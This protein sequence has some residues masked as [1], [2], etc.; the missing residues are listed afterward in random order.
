MQWEYR[1]ILFEFQKDGL[2]GDTFIDDEDIE[3]TLNE[4]GLQGW[5]LVNVAL[6]Q[7]GLLAFC[8]RQ[9]ITAAVKRNSLQEKKQATPMVQPGQDNGVRAALT[10]QNMQQENGLQKQRL[11]RQSSRTMSTLEDDAIGNIKIL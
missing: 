11:E 9:M 6:I 2:L 10:T 5:E 1:T 4:Q 8:K 3:Q 7:E